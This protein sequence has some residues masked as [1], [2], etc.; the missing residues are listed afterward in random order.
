MLDFVC[1]NYVFFFSSRGRHTSCALVTGGQTCALPILYTAGAAAAVSPLDLVGPIS[2]YK[3]YVAENVQELVAGTRDFTNAVKAGD[4][5]KAKKLFGPTRMSYERIEPVDE[6]FSDLDGAIDS[7]G[8][9]HEKAEQDPG[10]IGF[11]R[12][13][14]WKSTRSNQSP[15][16]EHRM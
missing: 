10:F 12:N 3:I 14:E 13:D 5:D 11:N 8:D 15:T 16:C 1:V 4:I 7:R 6:L 2:D 9:D